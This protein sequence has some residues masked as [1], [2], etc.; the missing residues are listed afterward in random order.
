MIDFFKNV[1]Y[2]LKRIHTTEFY[3]TPSAFNSGQRVNINIINWSETLENAW[4]AGLWPNA[5][6]LTFFLFF[7]YDAIWNTFLKNVS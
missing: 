2:F 1:T 4:I 5:Y 3:V 6:S 7:Y